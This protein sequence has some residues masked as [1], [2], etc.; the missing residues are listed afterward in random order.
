M[1][2]TYYPFTLLHAYSHVHILCPRNDTSRIHFPS[3]SNTHMPITL[4]SFYTYPLSTHLLTFTLTYP[5]IQ[6][7]LCF[8]LPTYI[9][10]K[11]ITYHTDN[12]LTYYIHTCQ[13]PYQALFMHCIVI[14][15]MHIRYSLSHHTISCN[16]LSHLFTCTCITI[17]F[18]YYMHTYAVHIHIIYIF[19]VHLSFLYHFMHT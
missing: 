19:H 13:L 5:Y 16:H 15:F 2:Y 9:L 3:I 17:Q 11:R 7:F 6:L 4:L 12:E 14:P 10:H 18:I 8:I 1:Q